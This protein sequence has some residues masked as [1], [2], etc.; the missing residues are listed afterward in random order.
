MIAWLLAFAVPWLWYESGRVGLPTRTLGD[1][2]QIA[3]PMDFLGV[4]YYIN[5]NLRV[6]FNYTKG[7]NEYTGDKTGQ[8]AV[9]TQ[10]SF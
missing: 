7:D 9:R 4:N 5:S 6:M 10:F 1:M 2:A 3:A 8:Y